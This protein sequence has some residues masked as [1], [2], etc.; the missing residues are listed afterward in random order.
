MLL[1]MEW[2]T[3]DFHSPAVEGFKIKVSDYKQAAQFA[4]GQLALK[5]GHGFPGTEEMSTE[6]SQHW[7]NSQ[8]GIQNQHIVGKSTGLLCWPLISIG[9]TNQP[10]KNHFREAT[11]CEPIPFGL[12]L[13]KSGAEPWK[14]TGLYQTGKCLFPGHTEKRVLCRN[15]QGLLSTS[16][17]NFTRIYYSRIGYYGLGDTTRFGCFLC[18]CI[19]VFHM[20]S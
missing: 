12:W 13:G 8:L 2:R 14:Q 4:V 10:P 1:R 11:F 5:I 20:N 18:V 15:M 3:Y 9:T 6:P 19:F 7:E 16:T 17:L